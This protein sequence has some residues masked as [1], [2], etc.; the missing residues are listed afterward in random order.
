M[1]ELEK[2]IGELIHEIPGRIVE[3]NIWRTMDGD[4]DKKIGMGLRNEIWCDLTLAI[5]NVTDNKVNDILKESM[6]EKI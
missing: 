5:E 6:G 1:V 4:I 3:K 2:R